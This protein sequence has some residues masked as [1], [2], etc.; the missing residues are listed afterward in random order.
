MLRRQKR[1]LSQNT[2]PFAC[3]LE[4]EGGNLVEVRVVRERGSQGCGKNGQPQTQNEKITN[5]DSKEAQKPLL[6]ERVSKVNETCMGVFYL[7]SFG[8]LWKKGK[9]S[10]LPCP[11]K[12]LMNDH[13]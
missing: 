10:L 8:S 2:T 12:L 13:I 4:N 11:P 1:V 7:L 9:K 5:R 6:Q 3:T